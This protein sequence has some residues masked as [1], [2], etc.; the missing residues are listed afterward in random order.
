MPKTFSEGKSSKKNRK[1][2]AGLLAACR[3]AVAA[4]CR[5]VGKVCPGSLTVSGV[6][7][8]LDKPQLLALLRVGEVFVTFV[9]RTGW[10][11]EAGTVRARPA[12]HK[13]ISKKL[14]SSS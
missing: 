12:I 11:L 2:G 14:L 10:V 6:G 13:S 5:Q 8:G 3:R 9:E 4:S 7:F 1:T